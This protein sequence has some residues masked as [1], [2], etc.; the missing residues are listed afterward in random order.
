MPKSASQVWG[1]DLFFL[2][3]R[4]M[5]ACTCAC[6]MHVRRHVCVYMHVHVCVCVH[7]HPS[8]PLNARGHLEVLIYARACK[9][10]YCMCVHV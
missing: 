1:D 10:I 5:C 2:R 3:R 9:H 4:H 6:I 7:V 8:P